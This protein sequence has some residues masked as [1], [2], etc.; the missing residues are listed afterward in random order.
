MGRHGRRNY[1]CCRGRRGHLPSESDASY[2]HTTENM[3]RIPSSGEIYVGLEEGNR[4]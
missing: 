4:T 1:R 2:P 3:L